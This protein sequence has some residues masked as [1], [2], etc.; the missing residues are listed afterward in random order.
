MEV[1][2]FQPTLDVLFYTKI[3]DGS[4]YLYRKMDFK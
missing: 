3:K 4:A 2:D 1:S